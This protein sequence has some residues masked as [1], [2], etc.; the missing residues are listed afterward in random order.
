MRHESKG[1][2]FLTQLETVVRGRHSEMISELLL[3]HNK[4]AI[5]RT[6]LKMVGTIDYTTVLRQTRKDTY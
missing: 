1:E 2:I 4:T 6:H 5:Q 3:S